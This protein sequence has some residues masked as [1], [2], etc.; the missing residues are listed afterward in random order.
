MNRY[1]LSISGTLAIDSLWHIGSGAGDGLLDRRLLR[2][3][4]GQPF[5]PGS[6]L[7]GILRE[8]CRQLVRACALH[9]YPLHDRNW[10]WARIARQGTGIIERVFGTAQH[11]DC[12]FVDHAYADLSHQQTVREYLPVTRTAVDRALGTVKAQ[13]LFSTEYA[14][15]ANHFQLAIEGHHLGLTALSAS[16]WPYEYLFLLGGIQLMNALGADRSIGKGKLS[17][18][19]GEVNCKVY[20][21]QGQ[22]QTPELQLQD[23]LHTIL[24]PLGEAELQDMI[25]MIREEY[26][27]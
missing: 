13:A 26:H 8:H 2:D 3:P 25:E 23:D 11:G 7:K 22:V 21:E 27:G 17:V 16:D 19:L 24:A 4:Q 14:L 9:T 10:T 15:P 12:L 6:T 1:Q 5:I 20:N 18:T